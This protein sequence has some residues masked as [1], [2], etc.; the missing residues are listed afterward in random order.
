MKNTIDFEPVFKGMIDRYTRI[1]GGIYPAYKSTGFTERNLTN[2]FVA[3]AES[4]FGKELMGWFEMPTG[5]KKKG[6]IDAFIWNEKANFKAAIEAKRFSDP[7]NK[8]RSIV[9]D[10]KRVCTESTFADI[11]VC[12]SGDKYVIVLADVW[13]ETKAKRELFQEWEP[14]LLRAKDKEFPSNLSEEKTFRHEFPPDSFLKRPSNS[15]CILAY[16][17]KIEDQ[18][19][20]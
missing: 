1:F 10:L 6:H 14:V 17:A 12:K 3:A 20:I 2:N 19:G 5:L 15:Y 7:V 16:V 8:M 11:S 13:L 4:C 9:S 18:G